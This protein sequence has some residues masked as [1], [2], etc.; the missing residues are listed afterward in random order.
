MAVNIPFPIPNHGYALNS[1]LRINL[2][3]IVAQF[4]AFNTGTATWDQVAIGIANNETGT[5]TFYNTNNANYLTFQAGTTSPSTTFTLPTSVPSSSRKFLNST[6]GGTMGWSTLSDLSSYVGNLVLYADGFGVIQEVSVGSGNKVLV[7]S[8]PPSYFS[9]LGTANQIIITAN[10]GNY[11]LSTPQDIG[12][13]SNVTFN[14]VQTDGGTQSNPGIRVIFSGSSTNTGL[15][16][17]SGT[18]LSITVAGTSRG[19]FD[20]AGDLTMTGSFHAPTYRATTSYQLS[21]STSGIVTIQALSSGG[22]YTLT[23]PTDDGNNNE[24]LKTDGNGVLSWVSVSS[25]GGADAALDNLASVAINT[26]LLPGTNNSIALGSSSKQWTSVFLSTSGIISATSNQLV[27]GTTRTVTLTAPTPASSSRTVTIP[28]L[29]ASYSI[30]G[31]EGTQTI[32]GNKTLSGTTN[33]SGLTASLPLQ[34]DSSQNI[35]STAIDLST[36]QITGNLGVTHLN[37]GTSASSTTFWRGDA[38]WATPVNNGTVNSGT[39]GRVGLYATSTTAISD[40]Y[41][42]NTHNITLAF[43]SQGSRSADL[44]LT[45]PNPGNA[46]TAANVVLD[47]GA[48]TIAGALTLSATLTMS[49]ATIAMGSQKITGLSNGTNATDATAFGQIK[50]LQVVY[51][52]STTVFNTT[53]STFQVANLS[54]SITPTSSS[55][56]I[57]IF[58]SGTLRNANSANT[59]CQATIMKGGSNILATNGGAE[60]AIAAVGNAFTPASIVYIDSPATTSSTTYAVGLRSTDNTT[61]VAFGD[62]QTQSMILMEIV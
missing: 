11:T 38:T 37:S 35:V 9:L 1:K 27:L 26:A 4:N 50:V 5:L 17:S 40:T 16:S 8:S 44:A 59:T 33:L 54:G 14:S 2:D 61:T 57:A 53:S 15:F 49:G 6:T 29:S 23:L 34:L 12:T 21:T 20:N 56:R 28:D 13:S 22:T 24:L 25:A 47:Q 10:V 19:T 55:N 42:Q 41:V 7:N 3:Y 48:Y 62:T 36:S 46:V 52:T 30:V 31:T 43:A 58:I 51:A 32:N 60:F 18:S 45:I 39:A